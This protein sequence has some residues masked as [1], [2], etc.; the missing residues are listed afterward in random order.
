MAMT[1]GK[2]PNAVFRLGTGRWAK[3]LASVTKKCDVQH[4]MNISTS[5][6]TAQSQRRH[7]ALV[8]A[9]T[10]GLSQRIWDLC[11]Q[12]THGERMRKR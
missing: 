12:M 1:S 3:Q 6:S 5:S 2:L 9:L 7:H 10:T 4:L 8:L 11:L